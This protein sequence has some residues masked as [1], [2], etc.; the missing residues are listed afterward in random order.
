MSVLLYKPWRRHID[1][2]R[3]Q[4]RLPQNQY[5]DQYEDEPAAP[6]DLELALNDDDDNGKKKVGAAAVTTTAEHPHHDN[7]TA[8]KV[9]KKVGVGKKDYD[10]GDDDDPDIIMPHDPPRQGGEGSL[11]KKREVELGEGGGD[12]VKVD[13][14]DKTL[15]G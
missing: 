9:G 1:R 10:D 7:D 14:K 4:S 12:E 5:E 6:A 15:L 3:Q 2:K 11:G 13:T 8:D